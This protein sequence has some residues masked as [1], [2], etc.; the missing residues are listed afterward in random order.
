MIAFANTKFGLIRIQGSEVK[1]GGGGAESAPPVWA[2]FWNLGPGRV[3]TVFFQMVIES[4]ILIK[5]VDFP[6]LWEG[7]VGK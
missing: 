2:S 5:R 6:N 3:K 4:T 1:R 7:H